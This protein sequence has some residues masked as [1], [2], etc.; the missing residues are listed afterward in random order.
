MAQPIQF[1]MREVGLALVT[2]AALNV[3][4]Y[5]NMSDSQRALVYK[6]KSATRFKPGGNADL[7]AELD[8]G[9]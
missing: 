9:H 8:C 3:E 1:T 2:L 6:A 4:D 5:P 7:S